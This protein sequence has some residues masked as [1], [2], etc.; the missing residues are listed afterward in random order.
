MTMWLFVNGVGFF[1]ICK[2]GAPATQTGTFGA[3]PPDLGLQG[4][5]LGVA[6]SFIQ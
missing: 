4:I 1:E 3:L 2:K 6:V 5:L